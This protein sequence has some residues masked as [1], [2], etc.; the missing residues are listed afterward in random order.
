VRKEEGGTAEVTMSQSCFISKSPNQGARRE[1]AVVRWKQR[2]TQRGI[3]FLLVKILIFDFILKLYKVL[4][5]I[6]RQ[7]F[8][9]ERKKRN[10][11]RKLK[12]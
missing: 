12:N 7:C 2:F 1:L 6:E 11:G 3:F 4:K 5:I 9:L 10:E 8:G